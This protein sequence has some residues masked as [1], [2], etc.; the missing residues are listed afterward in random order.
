MRECKRDP[1]QTTEHL[2]Y[3]QN[4]SPQKLWID[5]T[6]FPA[7]GGSLP[8]LCMLSFGTTATH[9]LNIPLNLMSIVLTYLKSRVDI[10][11]ENLIGMMRHY[12]YAVC[13]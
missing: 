3:Q 13:V 6:Y 7:Q 2:K 8:P 1:N 9:P 12:Y 11:L 5:P 10:S 4:N